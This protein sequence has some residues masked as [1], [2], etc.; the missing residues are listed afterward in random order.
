VTDVSQLGGLPDL[1]IVQAEVEVAAE[2][3]LELVAVLGDALPDLEGL[4]RERQLGGLAPLHPDRPLRA[5]RLLQA[6]GRVLLDHDDV[7]APLSESL[8][9]RDA[10]DPGADDDDVRG[11]RHVAIP[12]HRRYGITN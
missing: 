1:V 8:R 6:R 2:A 3:Q 12:R 5:P 10:A 9:S 4:H 11:F 7:C